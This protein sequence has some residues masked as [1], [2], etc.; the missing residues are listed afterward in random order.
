MHTNSAM[1]VHEMTHFAIGYLL[2]FHARSVRLY[3]RY[4][5]M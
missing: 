5:A 2:T 3:T 1:Q 4:V